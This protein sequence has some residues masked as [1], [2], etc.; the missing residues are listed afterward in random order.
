MVPQDEMSYS[1]SPAPTSCLPPIKHLDTC[2]L[3]QIRAG[4]DYLR[5]LYNPEVRGSR[6]SKQHNALSY[7]SNVL[8]LLHSKDD[9]TLHGINAIRGDAFERRYAIQWLT[10]LVSRADTIPSLQSSCEE[11]EVTS[12]VIGDAAALLALCAGPSSSGKLTRNF[13]FGPSPAGESVQVIL[14]DAPLDNSD[15][16]TVGAQ[17]WGGACVM[18]DMIL[19][20]PRQFGIPDKSSLDISTSKSFTVLELGSGTGLVG[21]TIS[22]LLE[23]RNIISSVVLTDFHPSILTNLHTNMDANFPKAMS[24][25]STDLRIL[26]LDWESF[27]TYDKSAVRSPLG[28][29]DLIVGADIV[30][31]EKHAVWIKCCV[32]KLLNWIPGQGSTNGPLFHLV[33][34]LRQT[35]VNESNTIPQVFGQAG[36]KSDFNDSERSLMILKQE[37]FCCDADSYSIAGEV[38]YA[39]YQIGWA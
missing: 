9:Q 4:V 3:S 26:R 38:Q 37:I 33:I 14:S 5:L 23:S 32:E 1:E 12:S 10:C 15:Y 7:S 36:V 30:Y 27:A 16:A 20:N 17:T 24:S 25:Y 8:A 2:S 13:T 35:H 19:E 22:K 21:L 29:F 28:P 34:P 31:E 39:Y 18:A 6:R 11:T